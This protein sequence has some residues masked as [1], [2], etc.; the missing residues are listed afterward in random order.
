MFTL[1]TN[2]FCDLIIIRLCLFTENS[3]YILRWTVSLIFNYIFALFTCYLV[4]FCLLLPCFFCFLEVDR[5][6]WKDASHCLES[7]MY[8]CCP[9]MCNYACTISAKNNNQKQ[10]NKCTY[11]KHTHTHTQISTCNRLL[12]TSLK[13][14]ITY[15][16]WANT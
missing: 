16:N 8:V 12:I 7:R 4:C 10:L 2:H 1:N 9:I 15:M 14:Y 3:L 5:S 6:F 11:C 13:I